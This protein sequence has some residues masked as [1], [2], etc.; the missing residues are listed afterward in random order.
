MARRFVTLDNFLDS[1][2]VSGVGWNWSVAARTTD[3]TEK[4]VPP[5]Y[6]DRGF[7]YAWEG[8]NR[9]INVGIGTLAE[10]KKVQPLL[11]D[12][13]DPNLLPGAVDVAAPDSENGDAGSGYIW[14]EALRAG[15]TAR[16]YGFFPDDSYTSNPKTNPAYLPTSRAPFAEN[17]KQMVPANKSL[18]N[19]T[20]LF[21]RSFDQ[22]M[23]DYWRVKEWEREFDAA[24]RSGNLANLTLLR[25]AH[26]HF[27]DFGTAEDGIDTPA[28]EFAD[29][30]YAVG[31]VAEKVAKSSVADSTLI[32]VV[33]DDAQDGPDR[34]DAHRSIAYVLG[35][36]VKHNAVVSERY[37]TVSMVHT[38]EVTPPTFRV[39]AYLQIQKSE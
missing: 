8:T 13:P 7:D 9:G 1:G 6:A 3:Y 32:F 31:L 10:R 33:E 4:T 14:D 27:G 11:G 12:N 26:D 19:L 29:N 36:Y 18:T 28:L 15:L 21:F 25:L 39:P 5:N 24:V 17:K 37:T 34:I 35:P 20:G 2:E 22:N 38:M 23:S 16:N 30:D